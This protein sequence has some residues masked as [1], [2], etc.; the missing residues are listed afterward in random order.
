MDVKRRRLAALALLAA[1]AVMGVSVWTGI[2]NSP[3]RQP[4]GD[5]RASSP[6]LRG[7]TASVQVEVR[8]G[9]PVSGFKNVNAGFY[10]LWSRQQPQPPAGQTPKPPLAGVEDGSYD[11]AIREALPSDNL[12][13]T[14]EGRDLYL[15]RIY[16]D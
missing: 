13:L 14:V 4:E 1:L 15:V 5:C 8:R 3:E 10:D 2:T 7:S 11:G 12:V 6:P 16:C 9:E